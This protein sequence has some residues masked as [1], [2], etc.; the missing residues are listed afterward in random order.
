M[1]AEPRTGGQRPT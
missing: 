1:T